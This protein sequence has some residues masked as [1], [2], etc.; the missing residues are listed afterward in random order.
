MPLNE[1]GQP[2]GEPLEWAAVHPPS[3]VRL[4]GR[5]CRVEPL[6]PERHAADLH[7]A[8]S[9]D[10]VGSMWTYM[11]YGPFGSLASYEQWCREV[12]GESDPMFLAIVDA[13]DG[14]AKGVA[15]YLRIEPALG[16][17]EVGHIAYSPGL[18]RTTAATEAMFLM[19]AHVF[20]E[21]GYRRLEWKC[22]ALN[23]AS[24]RAALRLG[25]SF[26]GVFRQATIYKGRNRD[27]AWYAVVDG[28][29][30]RL[31]SGFER[32]L[33]PVNFDDHGRQRRPLSL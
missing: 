28:D 1:Y 15:S 10:A 24:R 4:Q 14:L 27:T 22:D 23:E 33:D 12:A 25:F 26:E 18:Q 6:D 21:L 11:P 30:P 13:E 19:M 3:D 20:E 16:V 9:E 2:I 7:A 5:W 8:N 32:W 29:W 31:R 17:I